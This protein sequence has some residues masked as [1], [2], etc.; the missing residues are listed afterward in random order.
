[1]G[2]LICACLF[3]AAM[4]GPHM[5]ASP[6]EL[7]RTRIFDH[8]SIEI[9]DPGPWVLRTRKGAGWIDLETDTFMGIASNRFDL[10]FRAGR[11]GPAGADIPKDAKSRLTVR[12]GDGLERREGFLVKKEALSVKDTRMTSGSFRGP[13]LEAEFP[14]GSGF[15]RNL[16]LPGAEINLVNALRLRFDALI[17]S[18]MQTGRT[19]KDFRW[20]TRSLENGNSCSLRRSEASVR[21]LVRYIEPREQSLLICDNL[22][23]QDIE[24][25]IPGIVM[26]LGS[27]IALHNGFEVPDG[28]LALLPGAAGVQPLASITPGA[29]YEWIV[30]ANPSGAFLHW[31]ELRGSAVRLNPRLHIQSGRTGTVIG[32]RVDDIDKNWNEAAGHQETVLLGQRVAVL[33]GRDWYELMQSADFSASLAKSLDSSPSRWT[34]TLEMLP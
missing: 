13:Y 30:L 28:T 23:L 9:A 22:L 14:G 31:L 8:V 24:L 32:Y 5:T 3:A 16:R 2:F 15:F 11:M 1:M 34:A 12:T 26:N 20:T 27:R 17:L 25:A 21:A 29:A 19:E 7:T 4:N 6:A 18:I 33:G 10:H